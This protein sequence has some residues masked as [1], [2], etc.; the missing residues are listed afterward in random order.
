MV[1]DYHRDAIERSLEKS[2]SRLGVDRVEMVLIHDPDDHYDEAMREAYPVLER[3]RDSGVIGAIGVGMN[4]SAMLTRFAHDA[5]FDVFLLAGRYTVLDQSAMNDL[6]AV[7]TE[8]GVRLV[9]GGVLNSG[10]LASPWSEQ[11]MFNYVP[12]SAEWI[13]RARALDDV[14]RE[15]GVPL[16]AAALQFPLAHPAVAS[17]VIALR[18]VTEVQESADLWDAVIP[19]A[20][21][22]A[23]R[24]RGLIRRDAPAPSSRVE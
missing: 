24:D 9:L 12:A 17:V 11:P 19:E 14:C 22:T 6:M 18:S 7:A 5:D 16:K 21:W 23:L 3:W 4:Q 20:F 13:A 15:F 8:R 2:L 1:H 10:I